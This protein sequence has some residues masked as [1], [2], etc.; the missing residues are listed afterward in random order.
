MGRWFRLCSRGESPSCSW[1]ILLNRQSLEVRALQHDRDAQARIKFEIDSYL[2]LNG[3]SLISQPVADEDEGSPVVRVHMGAIL[4]Q[5]QRRLPQ[6]LRLPLPRFE[7][8]VERL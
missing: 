7:G 1:I 8:A 4:H 5:G 6:R 3:L 2:D